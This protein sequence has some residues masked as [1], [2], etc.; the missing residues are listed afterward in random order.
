MTSGCGR[1]GYLDLV[2]AVAIV[3]VVVYHATGAA[4]LTVVFP[5]MGVMF[6]LGG[7]LMAASLS[8]GRAVREVVG[9]RLRRLL[10]PLWVLGAVAVALMGWRARG[11]GDWEVTWRCLYWV[12]PVVDPPGSDWGAPLWEV[13]WYLRAY[14]WFVLLSPLLLPLFR[15]LPLL[16]LTVPF[17]VLVMLETERWYLPDPAGTIV[18]EFCTYA[19]C[20][21]LGFAHHDGLLDR[22]SGRVRIVLAGVLAAAGA[23]WFL[24]HTTEYGLDLGYI[25][26]G[27]ALWSAGFVVLLLGF[28]PSADFFTRRPRLVEALRR[29]NSRALSIYLWHNPSIAAAAVLIAVS[30]L[31][32]FPPGGH[33]VLL[34]ALVTVLTSGAVTTLGWAETMASRRRGASGSGGGRSGAGGGARGA[35]RACRPT[36]FRAIR[37]LRHRL[38]PCMTEARMPLSALL[39]LLKV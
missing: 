19:G 14:L 7:S 21:F 31:D 33:T 2:R 17:A 10:V 16:A 3:R 20:W 35:W 13:L 9:S 38:G 28:Q 27:N 23:A 5:S 1:S 12:L 6:G 24:T 26:L 39:A 15:R 11:D 37:C 25:P 22:L 8:R 30:G 36:G 18:G 4:W 34:L 32:D 29:I